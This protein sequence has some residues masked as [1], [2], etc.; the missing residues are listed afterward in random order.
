MARDGKMVLP[1]IAGLVV[2]GILLKAVVDELDRRDANGH[3]ERGHA[4]HGQG[5]HEEALGAYGDAL[6]LAPKDPRFHTAR[7]RALWALG[8]R[9]EA[10]GAYQR[11]AGLDSNGVAAHCD[12]ADALRLMG[13]PRDALASAERAVALSG[14]SSRAYRTRGEVL[15]SLDEGGK[16]IGDL[17]A[18]ASLHDTAETHVRIAEMR[19]GRGEH[20]YERKEMDLAISMEAGSADLHYR[21]ARALLHIA[22]EDPGSIEE[23]C[24]EAVTDLERAL[25]IDPRHEEAA[26]MLR[27]ARE[28]PEGGGGK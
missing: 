10:L 18:S 1:L 8:R 27:R 13:R 6:R 17:K 4:L 22:G 14:R 26:G 24:R 7:G 11:A 19:C 20:G 9:S 3:A 5:R 12:V 15:W 21:R 16:A 25:E 28:M 2:G 23:C